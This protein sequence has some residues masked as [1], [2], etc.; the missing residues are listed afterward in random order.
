MTVRF[1]LLIIYCL[2]ANFAYVS[3]ALLPPAMIFFFRNVRILS[4]CIIF[5]YDR[6]C[7][8]CSCDAIH[9]QTH[10]TRITLFREHFTV[11]YPYNV[12]FFTLRK[13]LFICEWHIRVNEFS[14]FNRETER[15]K[16]RRVNSVED[17][18]CNSVREI[19]KW[20]RANDVYVRVR[21]RSRTRCQ[22]MCVS[23]TELDRAFG[24]IARNCVANIN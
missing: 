6:Y 16:E 14:L 3:I 15:E 4:L 19:T 21:F 20:S 24:H 17:K 1:A 13:H 2:H 9:R 12:C 18:S 11:A 23:V 10:C 5:I 7:V 8:M 22:W